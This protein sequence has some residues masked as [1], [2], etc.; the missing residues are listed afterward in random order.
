MKL[1]ARFLVAAATF[2]FVLV[3]SG[4]VRGVRLQPDHRTFDPRGVRLEPDLK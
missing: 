3:A 4:F 2:T 1:R